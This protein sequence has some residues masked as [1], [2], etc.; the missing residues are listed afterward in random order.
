[1]D[2]ETNFVEQFERGKIAFDNGQYR[3]S[4]TD[5]EAA[6]KL[7]PLGSRSGGEVQLWLVMAYQAAG[8]LPE[9]KTL[10]RK[11]T[12]HPQADCRK[13]SKQVLFILEA[14]SLARPK[15]WMTEIPD[16]SQAD[17]QGPSYVQ[18]LP[19]KKIKPPPSP[20]YFEDP[21]GMNTEDNGFLGLAIAVFVLIAIA[22][23]GGTGAFR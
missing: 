17:A 4:I 10:C 16:L 19:S 2:S 11:L 12:R 18:S 5:F 21:A 15:E 3:Q 13:Q 1:M 22:I 7:T 8:Q 6:A 9:A 23:I 14:P 20:I